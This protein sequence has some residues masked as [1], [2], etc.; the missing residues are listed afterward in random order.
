MTTLLDLVE[1]IALRVDAEGRVTAASPAAP[2]WLAARRGASL[3]ALFG[4]PSHGTLREL[5]VRGAQ[6]RPE[7]GWP[8][9]PAS[10]DLSVEPS[11]AV[12]ALGAALKP[13]DVLA[14]LL[15]RATLI[16]KSQALAVL[17]REQVGPLAE[18]M[19]PKA[20]REATVLFIDAVG[21]SQLASRVDPVTCLKQLDF[22]FSAFDQITAG[23]GVEKLRTSGDTYMAVAGVPHRRA[24]HAVDATMAALRCAQ[25]VAA[26]LT[27]I[28]DEWDWSFRFG[29]HAGPCIS[30]VLG[31]R[32]P[33]YDLWG[34]TVSIANHV[35]RVGRPDSVSVSGSVHRLI[36]PFFECVFDGT[37]VARSAG[38]VPIYVVRGLRPEFAADA[39]GSIANEAF[40][41]RYQARFGSPCPEIAGEALAIEMAHGLDFAD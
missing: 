21:F 26:G 22:F 3:N 11:G 40:K 20:F 2:R 29:L 41:E 5:A 34:D 19:Q 32:R 13:P 12:L 4:R 9:G 10:W 6:A 37:T 8:E 1:P 36:E 28:V 7:E 17:P 31:S 15:G 23:F 24:S 33:V 39:R 38:D 30:G 35:E 25:V 18:R 16:E 14:G 27:P